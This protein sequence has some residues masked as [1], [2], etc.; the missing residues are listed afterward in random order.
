MARPKK[1]QDTTVKLETNGKAANPRDSGGASANAPSPRGLNRDTG[2]PVALPD[3]SSGIKREIPRRIDV[4]NKEQVNGAV[5]TPGSVY[6]LM[7]GE[8]PIYKQKTAEEYVK[9]L[10]SLDLH[11]L[12]THAIAVA[13]II[14]NVDKKQVLI[15]KLEKE[16]LKKQYQFMDDP[17]R[18]QAKS[19]PPE[20]DSLTRRGR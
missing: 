14:P 8:S 1:V 2:A 4:T 3:V 16:F 12:Q 17:R 19:L 5:S 15:D 18:Y 7:G 9:Y 13:N 20:F 11:D 10:N 6:S